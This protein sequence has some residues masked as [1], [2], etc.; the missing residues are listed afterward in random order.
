PWLHFPINA[1]AMSLIPLALIVLGAQLVERIRWPNWGIVGPVMFI[2]LIALP[3]VTAAVVYF[4][5][6]WPWPGAQIVL[7]AAATTAV[8]TLLLTMEFDGD[9]RSEERRVGTDWRCR[10][11]T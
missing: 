6:Y 5:G 11:G 2:K 1:L 8:N 10:S 9:A 7:A 3:A 4:M